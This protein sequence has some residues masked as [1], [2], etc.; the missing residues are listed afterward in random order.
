MFQHS[1]ASLFTQLSNRLETL[2]QSSTPSNLILMGLGFSLCLAG[3]LIHITT[4]SCHTQKEKIFSDEIGKVIW[5][6]DIKHVEF[7]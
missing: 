3:I 7:S 4:Q 2:R 6:L 1:D 5:K